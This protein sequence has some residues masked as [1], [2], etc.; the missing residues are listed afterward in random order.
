M[1]NDEQGFRE[2][3]RIFCISEFRELVI[4]KY[5]VRDGMNVDC[6]TLD[7]YIFADQRQEQLIVS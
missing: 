7:S 4:S 2:R 3:H 6:A 1:D 5:L